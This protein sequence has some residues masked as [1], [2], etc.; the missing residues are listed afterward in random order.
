VS[1]EESQAIALAFLRNSPTF[2][3]DGIEG[4]IKLL[5]S[6]AGAG[7]RWEFD[8]EFQNRQAGYGNRA[9]QFLAQVITSHNARI[10]VDQG[11]VTSAILDSQ[12]D[13]LK[14]APTR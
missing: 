12:W 11:Q 14:Q 2:K 8:F 5:R 6:Q 13:E 1:A 4:S 3:F 10:V 9:G 7:S